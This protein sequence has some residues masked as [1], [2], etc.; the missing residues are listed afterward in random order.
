MAQLA[1][2]SVYLLPRADTRLVSRIT[3]E[4]RPSVQE[5]LY[6]NPAG[7][8][9]RALRGE[10]LAAAGSFQDEIPTNSPARTHD[11]FDHVR[12]PRNAESGVND[13]N[14]SGTDT[15]YSSPYEDEEDVRLEPT[16]AAEVREW[17]TNLDR[18]ISTDEDQASSE[19]VEDI[20]PTVPRI[21]HTA[22]GL[23]EESPT[24]S[25]S[26]NLLPSLNH[27]RYGRGRTLAEATEPV[28]S[29]NPQIDT[30]TIPVARIDGQTTSGGENA[31]HGF[32]TLY[33]PNHG[34][35][36]RLGEAPPAAESDGRPMSSRGT[37]GSA[38][39]RLASGVA[40]LDGDVADLYDVDHGLGNRPGT[41]EID[42]GSTPY[43]YHV[44]RSGG[45]RRG[46]ARRGGGEAG[47]VTDQLRVLGRSR[48]E[49]GTGRTLGE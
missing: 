41:G 8:L 38:S 37:N 42:A 7:L 39:R 20:T 16:R 34:L 48:H 3:L 29:P 46:T 11:H 10:N 23:T 1:T 9:R 27:R 18:S 15:D 31:V 17:Q 6:Y 26:D 4:V 47:G 25:Q 19:H 40:D 5:E 24:D 36:Q 14:T 33:A 45:T 2:R 12:A 35:G 30:D 22:Q 43:L 28:L 21:H 13:A 44:G 49:F 32:V